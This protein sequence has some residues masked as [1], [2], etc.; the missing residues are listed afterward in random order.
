MY[1]EM[2]N[3]S[4]AGRIT[5]GCAGMYKPEH[6]KAWQRVTHFIHQNSAAKGCRQL[7]HAGRKGSTKYPWHGEDEPLENGNWPLISASPLPFK[8]FNQVP[9]EM[10]RDDM[11]DVLDSFVR[12]AH[13][14]EEAEFDMIEIHMAHGYLL[15]SFISPVS[16]VRRDEY[17]GELVNRLK[18]P[19]EILKAV[20]S[21]WPNS[22]PISCRISATDWLDS[23]GLTGEDAV[24]V[25][26]QLYENGCDIIDVS[27]GQTTPEAEPIY[28]RMFQT[29]LSEQVRLEAKG[30]T[31]AVG[32]ITSADQVN[33]IVAAGRAD[34]VA[35]ARPHLT[36]P[37]FTLKAAAHY[38]YTPQFW[39][40]QYLAGKAQAERLAEQDNIRLQEI[41]LANRPKSHND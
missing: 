25:A 18:F 11:D 37:H 33:T 2:T 28:G 3:V 23:G 15:S 21:V 20:R 8:E 10:T 4:A 41:L 16:N 17:G 12:A 5:P 24:E 30:P 31:I 32:N 14:A 40:E 19:V 27:A 35:L 36:D 26:K 13:M 7:A 6:V 29:H 39:P 22:K 34:L 9:K 1:T 38:G